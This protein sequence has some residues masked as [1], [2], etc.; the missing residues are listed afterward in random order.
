MREFED[1]KC[2]I[3][4]TRKETVHKHA[5]EAVLGEMSCYFGSCDN[6]VEFD[7]LWKFIVIVKLF[8]MVLFFVVR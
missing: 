7:I 5:L 4:V 8:E 2:V 1:E 6:L 3:H